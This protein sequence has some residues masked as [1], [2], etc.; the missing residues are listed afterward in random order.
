MPQGRSIDQYPVIHIL[1]VQRKKPP[2]PPKIFYSI[3]NYYYT[4]YHKS[5]SD[6]G[7]SA[8]PLTRPQ[9][10]PHANSQCHKATAKQNTTAFVSTD[11]VTGTVNFGFVSLD[12]S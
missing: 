12:V 7:I 4:L 10:E 6:R 8:V 1:N 11:T 3:D 2:S 9:A 5:E